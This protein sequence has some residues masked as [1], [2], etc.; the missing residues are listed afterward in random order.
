M[1]FWW[2]KECGETPSGIDSQAL[3]APRTWRATM[4]ETPALVRWSDVWQSVSRLLGW[5][6]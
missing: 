2:R 3:R 4:S 1:A 6:S 5:D